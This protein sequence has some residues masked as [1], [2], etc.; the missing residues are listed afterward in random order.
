ME[1]MPFLYFEI[2]MEYQPPRYE[3]DLPISKDYT[4]RS[5]TIVSVKNMGNSTAANVEY[6]WNCDGFIRK[7]LFPARAMMKSDSDRIQ[8]FLQHESSERRTTKGSLNMFYNDML[9]NRYEQVIQFGISNNKITRIKVGF[10]EYKGR[11]ISEQ[12]EEK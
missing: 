4:G 6:D 3:M 12:V 8:L 10:P 7:G 1:A 9:G 11:A 2:P 5:Y